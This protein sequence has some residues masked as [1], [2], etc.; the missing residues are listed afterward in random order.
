M[1]YYSFKDSWAKP[2][3][4]A[5]AE[6]EIGEASGHSASSPE[7]AIVRSKFGGLSH[8]A[9]M[10]R[11]PLGFFCSMRDHYGEN[12]RLN[13]GHHRMWLVTAPPQI[14]AL[15][16]RNECNVERFQPALRVM[17]Q[18]FHDSALLG[19]GARAKSSRRQALAA[20]A[21]D[22]LN[23]NAKILRERTTAAVESMLATDT[24]PSVDLEHFC[25]IQTLQNVTH[26]LMGVEETLDQE[27]FVEAV[28]QSSEII[29]Q[30][31]TSLATLPTFIP[32]PRNFRKRRAIKIIREHVARIVE[33]KMAI[34]ANDPRQD[35][36][37]A[38]ILHLKGDKRK[39][40]NEIVTLIIAGFEPTATAL[41]WAFYLMG[42][43]RE[44]VIRLQEELDDVLAGRP[45]DLDDLEKLPCLRRSVHEVLRLYPTAFSLFPRQARCDFDL[46]GL[47]IKRGE[48][49]QISP[50][51]THRSERWFHNPDQFV[52]DRFRVEPVAGSYLPF[53]A[54]P[55][56]CIGQRAAF[57]VIAVVIAIVLQRVVPGPVEEEVPVNA[58]FFLRPGASIRQQWFPREAACA[59]TPRFAAG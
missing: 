25:R 57:M 18:W 42:R 4:C 14:N 16:M 13:I 8:L 17:S 7:F 41:T 26:A 50:Y 35:V 9:H 55:R 45:P 31:L 30:E 12:P 54:G 6:V 46:D 3:P 29:V 47:P 36:L 27:P 19:E 44:A 38:M 15:L 1:T 51:L 53:G 10:R 20:L 59:E 33:L 5:N 24:A 22:R 39:I 52:P 21:K 34:G 43:D 48:L 28:Y 58:R 40:C 32:T 23:Q 37:S 56:G 2:L 11:D 49:L